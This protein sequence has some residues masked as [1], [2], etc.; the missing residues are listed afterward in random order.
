MTSKKLRYFCTRIKDEYGDYFGIKDR[1]TK[2]QIACTIYWH[3]SPREQV[4]A[5]RDAAR[6]VAALNAYRPGQEGS[7]RGGKPHYIYG[8]DSEGCNDLFVV[9][10]TKT[11]KDLACTIHW[12][13]GE[14]VDAERVIARITNALNAY[15]PLKKRRA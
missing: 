14:E 6:I 7:G 3:C 8:P 12:G 10:D 4:S 2:K 1:R 11:G 13:D 9:Q 15:Q 5:K